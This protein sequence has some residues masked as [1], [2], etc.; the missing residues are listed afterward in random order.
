[1]D[2]MKIIIKSPEGRGPLQTVRSGKSLGGRVFENETSK[3]RSFSANW[4][5]R[6]CWE[7]I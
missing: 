6:P 4:R 7:I 2:V 3:M 5:T 1:M